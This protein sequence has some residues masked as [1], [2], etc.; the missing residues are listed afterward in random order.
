MKR[1]DVTL[2]CKDIEDL[3]NMRTVIENKL[4]TERMVIRDLQL[5]AERAIAD[6]VHEVLDKWRLVTVDS[7]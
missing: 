1:I 6:E 5:S 3:A 2:S 7:K 4:V